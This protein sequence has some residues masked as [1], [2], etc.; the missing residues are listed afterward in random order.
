M[1]HWHWPIIFGRLST[2]IIFYMC[3]I[4]AI[5]CGD[6][7]FIDTTDKST[8]KYD[9]KQL[10]TEDTS[11]YIREVQRRRSCWHNHFMSVAVAGGGTW[12]REDVK[13]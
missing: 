8:G 3:L 13:I 10:S 5:L 9:L 4:S 6:T 11:S 1:M 12:M 7:Q 2:C